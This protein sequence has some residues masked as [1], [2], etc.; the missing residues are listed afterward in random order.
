M[1]E[2]MPISPSRLDRN[3]LI[4]C[5]ERLFGTFTASAA[6]AAPSPPAAA[7]PEAPVDWSALLQSTD[8]D[9]GIARELV[10]LLI[11]SGDE[12]LARIATAL[13]KSDYATMARRRIRSR[14]RA[15]VSGRRP[16]PQAAAKLEAAAKAADTTQIK[17]LA[18]AVRGEVTRTID[19]LKKK[20]RWAHERPRAVAARNTPPHNAETGHRS[21][22][23]LLLGKHVPLAAAFRA[24]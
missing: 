7:C 2:W 20:W 11:A 1:P 4:A 22:S 9:E 13:G 6:E 8:G 18:A 3:L 15:P 5:L 16:R 19:Y 12:T 23:C 14:E 24:S 10:E 21:V 17:S